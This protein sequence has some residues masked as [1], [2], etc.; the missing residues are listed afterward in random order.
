MG[1]IVGMATGDTED[2][3][4][5]TQPSL[6]NLV[7]KPSSKDIEYYFSHPFLC[8]MCQPDNK[9]SKLGDIGHLGLITIKQK[10]SDNDAIVYQWI[11]DGGKQSSSLLWI[12]DNTGN[13]LKGKTNGDIIDTQKILFFYKADT[14][15]ETIGSHGGHMQ[16]IYV[17]PFKLSLSD[18]SYIKPS[19]Q[20]VTV[21]YSYTI[22]LPDISSTTKSS[23][24]KST[25]T[26]MS[27]LDRLILERRTRYAIA[28]INSDNV[29][30]PNSSGLTPLHL[31]A[32]TNNIEMVKAL[33]EHNANVNPITGL[34]MPLKI[35]KDNNYK[36]IYDLL[37]EHGAVLNKSDIKN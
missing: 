4:V 26:D 23:T 37:K 14:K 36:E 25:K 21:T 29:N 28:E 35:A 8:F 32:I 3:S 6:V 31:A 1:I 13:I 22:E 2:I 11:C 17:E 12:H 20:K 16:I 30:V 7:D 15:F 5:S 24:T 19:I 27:F 34:R 9:F 33:L 10:F 18:I